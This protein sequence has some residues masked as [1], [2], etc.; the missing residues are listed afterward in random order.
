MLWLLSSS[1][2]CL[3]HDGEQFF[4]A[5]SPDMK[6][7]LNLLVGLVG[8]NLPLASIPSHFALISAAVF[9]LYH[10]I[11]H[12]IL[13]ISTIIIILAIISFISTHQSLPQQ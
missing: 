5:F 7:G 9:T 1:L 13:I 3:F 8:A 12:V 10:F 11:C 2:Y 6:T 4:S